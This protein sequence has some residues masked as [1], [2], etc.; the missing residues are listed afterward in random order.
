MRARNTYGVWK[1]IV[2][3]PEYYYGSKY[4]KYRQKIRMELC[5][6]PGAPCS[7][8]STGYVSSCVQKYRYVSLLVYTHVEGL[9]MDSFKLPVACSCHVRLPWEHSASQGPTHRPSYTYRPSQTPTY[10]PTHRPSTTR[11]PPVYVCQ[12]ASPAYKYPSPNPYRVHLG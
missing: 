9:H 2:N 8:V 7:Y 10:R 11:L 12:P 4:Y 6:Y 5:I 1:V 3:I